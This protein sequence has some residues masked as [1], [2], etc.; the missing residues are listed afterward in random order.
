MLKMSP[1]GESR[2]RVLVVVVVG[3]NEDSS[4]LTLARTSSAL[5]SLLPWEVCLMLRQWEI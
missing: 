2:P 1:P 4:Q 3:L 5:A